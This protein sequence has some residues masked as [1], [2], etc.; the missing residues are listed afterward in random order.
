VQ[1][2]ISKAIMA[3]LRGDDARRK[4]RALARLLVAQWF[5]RFTPKVDIAMSALCH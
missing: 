3:V 1:R 5:V 4:L 2:K